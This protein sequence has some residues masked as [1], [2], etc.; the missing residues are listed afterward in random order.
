VRGRQASCCGASNAFYADAGRPVAAESTR[1]TGLELVNGSSIQ[2]LPAIERTTRG[3]STD[4]L[5]V[6]EAGGVADEDYYGLLPTLAA[7][8]GDQCLLG[9]PRGRRGFLSDIYHA[10]ETDAEWFK[11]LV[12]AEDQQHRISKEDLAMFRAQMPVLLFRQ[13]FLCEWLDAENA[14][15]PSEF[16]EAAIGG[17][18]ATLD[19]GDDRWGE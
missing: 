7:T 6:D 13:E 12:T 11:T 3:Y 16:I 19:F 1:R 5:V 2:A 14:F 4:L 18:V 15:F 17:D 10:P 9:T 8:Q